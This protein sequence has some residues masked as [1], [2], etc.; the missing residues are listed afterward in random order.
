MYNPN[1]PKKKLILPLLLLQCSQIYSLQLLIIA[2]VNFDRL[3]TFQQSQ[4]HPLAYATYKIYILLLPKTEKKIDYLLKST[5][6][7]VLLRLI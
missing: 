4:I 2:A 1:K 6:M 5:S 7:V 3:Q